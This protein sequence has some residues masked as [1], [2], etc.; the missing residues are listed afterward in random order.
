MIVSAV[1][2]TSTVTVCVGKSTYRSEVGGELEIAMDRDPRLSLA[3]TKPRGFFDDESCHGP[4]DSG[5]P[6]VQPYENFRASLWRKKGLGQFDFATAETTL[7][8]IYR[9]FAYFSRQVGHA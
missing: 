5:P 7:D 3:P 1:L 8:W 9:G 6:T 4:L 2:T